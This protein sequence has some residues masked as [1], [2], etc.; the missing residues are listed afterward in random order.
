M[1]MD[2]AALGG[3]FAALIATAAPATAAPFAGVNFAVWKAQFLGYSD[4]NSPPTSILPDGISISCFGNAFSFTNGCLG[5]ASLLVF[6]GSDSISSIG[7]ISITN[8]SGIDLGTL[9]FQ[10]DFSA[11]NPGGSPIG[12]QVD[13]PSYQYA[14]FS[15]SVFGPGVGDFHACDTRINPNM[16]PNACGVFS[17]DSSQGQFSTGPLAAGQNVKQSYQIKIAATVFVPEPLTL[18]L[19]GAGLA[20]T[21]A[22]RR[23]R[24]IK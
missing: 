2:K 19:F 13:D 10:T 16:G 11:F 15:S 24:A 18:S 6:D 1:R 7:G 9:F 3:I 5:S 22:L 21:V 23:R 12:A 20:G 4:L 17:P 14:V 8:N